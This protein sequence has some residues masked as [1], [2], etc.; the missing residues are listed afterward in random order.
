MFGLTFCGLCDF[1]Q[2]KPVSEERIDFLNS[3]IVKYMSNN[4]LCELNEG[5]RCNDNRLLQDAY[6]CVNGESIEPND[7]THEEHDLCLCWTNHA[8]DALSQK[9]NQ[10][11]VKGKRIEVVG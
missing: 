3:W 1:K 8:V 9:W 5:H 11:Y 7:F 4:R 6:T 2:L 10:H